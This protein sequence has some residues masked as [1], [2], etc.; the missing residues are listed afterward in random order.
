[1]TTQNF[2]ALIILERFFNKELRMKNDGNVTTANDNVSIR[3]L[4]MIAG[5]PFAIPL[6]WRWPI[7]A[8]IVALVWLA[9]VILFARRFKKKSDSLNDG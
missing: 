3:Y 9:S 7:V 1:L 8:M 5:L 4:C 2:F 6:V